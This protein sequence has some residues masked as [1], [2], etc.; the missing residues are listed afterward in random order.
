MWQGVRWAAYATFG[1]QALS[2][3]AMAALEGRRACLL[4]NHGLLAQHET[5][6]SALALAAEVESLCRM[7]WQALQVGEPVVLDADQMAQVHA[8]FAGYR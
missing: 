6:A 4:A 2:A 7:Y 3:N 8:R 1:R 5:L